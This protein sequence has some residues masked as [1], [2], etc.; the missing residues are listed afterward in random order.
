MNVEMS[1]VKAQETPASMMS[2]ELV[3]HVADVM[4]IEGGI[5]SIS[6]IKYVGGFGDRLHVSISQ[7]EDAPYEVRS[8]GVI[9]KDAIAQILSVCNI[10]R[11]TVKMEDDEKANVVAAW[12]NAVASAKKENSEA[13]D[14][15]TESKPAEQRDEPKQEEQKPAGPQ[16][17]NV[18]V[19]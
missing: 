9:I 5:K 16:T 14:V 11:I 6:A 4:M 10:S 2:K 3:E 7:F 19:E 8:Q 13:T 12:N 1:K 17:I 15:T 18:S